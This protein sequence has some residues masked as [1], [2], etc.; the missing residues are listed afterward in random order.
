MKKAELVEIG[1][2]ALHV[3]FLSLC[4]AGEN[5]PCRASSCGD[6]RTISSPFRLKGDP[7]GCGDPDP[8]YELVCENN[9]RTIL[10]GKYYVENIN[11]DKSIIRVVVPGLKKGNCFTPPL[12]SL[13]LQGLLYP[14]EYPQEHYTIVLM[15]CTRA[16]HDYKHIPITSC[17]G[18]NNY[19]H[20]LISGG[21]LTA[22]DIH[23]SCTLGATVVTGRFKEVPE[24]RN[25]TSMSD[26]QGILL[27]GLELSFLYLRC[28]ECKGG[29]SY[30]EPNFTDCSIR[31]YNW[32]EGRNC[33]CPRIF[34]W[35]TN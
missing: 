30:C 23:S 13:T 26:L 24:L 20:A 1:T 22:S 34:K 11:Y 15:T 19:T 25:S 4:V 28:G 27:M 2:I 10:Y 17:D 32:T 33:E 6:I 12:Y 31:C 18:R 29:I 5:Q 16:I 21:S 9:N 8:A 14:Y 35:R 7:P 3:W